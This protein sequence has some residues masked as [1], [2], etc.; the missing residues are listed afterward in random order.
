PVFTYQEALA[1]NEK[2]DYK[3]ADLSQVMPDYNLLL[4]QPALDKATA[5]IL[6]DFLPFVLEQHKAGE[7]R[8]EKLDEKQVQKLIDAIEKGDW[9]SQPPY[10]PIKA[11]P[12]KT[13]EMAPEAVAMMKING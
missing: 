6:N 1:R 12:E 4:E 13:K 5:Y 2:S 8:F 10:L 11:V 3:K 7:K 9:E